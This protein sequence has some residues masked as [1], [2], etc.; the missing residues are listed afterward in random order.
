MGLMVKYS[1]IEYM[2][3][4]GGQKTIL[5]KNRNIQN[6]SP[7]SISILGSVQNKKVTIVFSQGPLNISPIISCMFA[8]DTGNDVLIGTPGQP[9]KEFDSA[10]KKNTQ[11]F[12]SLSYRKA[13]KG[14]SGLFHYYENLLWCKG[15][16]NEEDNQFDSLD[17]ETKPK[18]GDSH[19]KKK[20]EKTYVN[21]LES[22]KFQKWPKIV[23]IPI[24]TITPSSIIGSKKIPYK[25]TG[26]TLNKF[27][28]KLI[29]FESIN[30]RR[31]SFD[32]LKKLIENVENNDVKLVLH[33]SWPYLNGVKSFIEE[34]Q[35][36][37]DVN[38]F[39]FGKRFCIETGLEKSVQDNDLK[40]LSLESDMWDVY[41]PKNK[42]IEYELISTCEDIGQSE[43]SA[44]NLS[45]WDFSYDYLV[46]AIRDGLDDVKIKSYD[47]YLLAFPPIF[48]NVLSPSEI[49]RR[50]KIH[51]VTRTLPIADTLSTQNK[52]LENPI[53]NFRGLCNDFDMFRD[54]TQELN[55]LHTNSRTTKKTQ[56]QAYLLEKIAKS[57]KQYGE[58]NDSCNEIIVVCN[59]EPY[60]FTESKFYESVSYLINTIGK[61]TNDIRFYTTISNGN[62][63][64]IHVN[65]NGYSFKY[66]IIISG[67][68][69]KKEILDLKNKLHE[70]NPTLKLQVD[71]DKQYLGKI[72]I[73]V[74]TS[75]DYM[76][77][78]NEKDRLFKKS[79]EKLVVYDNSIN[80]K[81]SNIIEKSLNDL[82]CQRKCD[83]SEI[84]FV[85]YT[86]KNNEIENQVSKKIEIKYRKLV[87]L[88]NMNLNETKLC[89]LIMPGSLPFHSLYEDELL[90]A[91]GFDSLMRPF[92][93]IIFMTYPGKDFAKARTQIDVFDQL[94]SEKHTSVS[95]IDLKFSIEHTTD[96]H[97]YTFPVLP[98]EEIEGKSL[99]I[100]SSPSDSSEEFIKT[101]LLSTEQIPIENGKIAIK[102]IENMLQEIKNKNL[103]MDEETL[104]KNSNDP[105][106][107]NND[108]IC[109]KVQYNNGIVENISFPRD[110]IIRRQVGDGYDICSV[111]DI[112]VSNRI[113][114]IK[115]EERESVENYLMRVLFKNSERSVDE[116]LEPIMCF[117]IFYN[118]LKLMDFR[119]K[120]D[121]NKMKNIYW[122]SE[123]KKKNLFDL[124]SMLNGLSE[125]VAMKQAMIEN[126][127]LYSIYEES[128]W[129][130]LISLEELVSIFNISKTPITKAK[131]Y[132]ISVV[133]GLDYVQES[134]NSLCRKN[135]TDSKHYSFHNPQNLLAI[136]KLM[137]HEK[138]I[139]NYIELNTYGQNIRTFLQ[140]VGYSIKRVASG[141][142][143]FVNDIDLAIKDKMQQCLVL[144]KIS[145]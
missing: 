17:V 121:I 120:D 97:A 83:R 53:S 44:D 64:N 84:D 70:L 122:L 61:I 1:S 71:Y 25:K 10:F 11:I 36:N 63:V 47:A 123:S 131:M 81:N 134:F 32:S 142:D 98:N 19:F 89:E 112:E 49:T 12:H 59:I 137:G 14:G 105:R 27:D 33:F 101:Q 20:F 92:T 43:I 65:S 108:Y 24:N 48:S 68:L 62:T 34:I 93:N 3:E 109:F 125:S 135:V 9:K 88:Q 45:K 103:S 57:I 50:F 91:R 99:G 54:L 38:I 73:F 78:N 94:L 127:E 74:D 35:D 4:K 52:S 138:I 58:S 102:S 110:S 5:D 31:Y 141:R 113:L 67:E 69:I 66:P 23:T 39:H 116:I 26:L 129:Y 114:Y 29:I 130:K 22:G 128:I 139:E 90:I 6:L 145:E 133:M 80:L 21:S 16:I 87:D 41:Y 95:L 118:S 86:K 46:Y 75:I 51:G 76:K 77:L 79:F 8:L 13:L 55:G 7:F 30:E 107:E 144:K 115:S 37:R 18:H 60:V 104:G 136:G 28:P 106:R 2:M 15:K 96:Y 40:I 56:F 111:N 85:M 42:K 140:Q 126:S 100:E 132:K 82:S 124:I 117:N 119:K 143:V 72:S